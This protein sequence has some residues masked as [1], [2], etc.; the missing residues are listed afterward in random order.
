M[1]NKIIDYNNEIL[2]VY[3]YDS[4]ELKFFIVLDNL[5]NGP[6]VGACRYIKHFNREEALKE[7]QRMARTMTDKNII[8]GIPFGGGKSFIYYNTLEKIEMLKVFAEALNELEGKYY[9]TNDIG[10]SIEDLQLLKQ[11]SPYVKGSMIS[12]SYVPSTAYSV[13]LALKA[14]VKFYYK[15]DTL[16]D[17]K[18]AVQGI[19]NVGYPLSKF[20]YNDGCKLF[21]NEINNDTIIKLSKEINFEVINDNFALSDVNILVPCACGDV[22]TSSNIDDLKAKIIVGGANNQ[23]E[24]ENLAE[25]LFDRNICFVPDMLANCGGMI[26]LYCEGE[27]YSEEYVFSMIDIIYE[28]VYELLELSLYEKKSPNQILFSQVEKLKNSSN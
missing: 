19:G 23:L 2:G 7:V 5:V 21:V 17:L 13:Y 12:D 14:A 18:I 27:N 25:I 3:E 9:V 15:K 28:K 1:L 16:K 24:D 11:Y 26:D 20:L 6:A 10:V 22:I 4:E 8:A